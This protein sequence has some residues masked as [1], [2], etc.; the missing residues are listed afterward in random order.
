[1]TSESTD[2][3]F[4]KVIASVQSDLS[5]LKKNS[6]SKTVS[7]TNPSTR[8]LSENTSKKLRSLAFAIDK[9]RSAV[10]YTCGRTC[11]YSRERWHRATTEA[12]HLESSTRCR[13]WRGHGRVRGRGNWSGRG[14]HTYHPF[15]NSTQ[16]HNYQPPPSPAPNSESAHA[17]DINRRNHQ[18]YGFIAKVKHRSTVVKIREVKDKELLIGTG[19]TDH[20][21]HTRG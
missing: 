1:M 5:Q 13:A 9:K 10:C 8:K 19:G 3:S 15:D 17:P 11:H 20:F 6:H 21:L 14:N 18:L 7:Q 12:P 16:V 4:Y 2:L